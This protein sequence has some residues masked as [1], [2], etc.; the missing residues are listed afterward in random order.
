AVVS[1]GFVLRLIGRVVLGSQLVARAFLGVQRVIELFLRQGRL[2]GVAVLGGQ[3]CGK[4][5]RS[6]VH[7]FSGSGVGCPL[8]AHGY[9]SCCFPNSLAAT[10]PLSSMIRSS[11]RTYSSPCMA[12]YSFSR[13]S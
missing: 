11:R 5:L 9:L 7:G 3:E 2:L 13:P 8:V 6:G 1:L 10:L 12:Q 4:L